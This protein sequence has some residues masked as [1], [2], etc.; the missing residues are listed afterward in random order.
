MFSANNDQNSTYR[1][2]K[3]FIKNISFIVLCCVWLSL[4]ACGGK[5]DEQA[6]SSEEEPKTK[7]ESLVEKATSN[8]IAAEIQSNKEKWLSHD[9]TEYQIEMQ[10][11]CFCVPDAVRLM[12]FE[13]ANNEIHAVRYADTGDEVDPSH[14]NQYNTVEGLFLLVEEALAKN[15][16]DISIAYDKEYGYIK[17]LSIDYQVNI[18]DDETTIIASNMKPYK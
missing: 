7:I 2:L 17:E 18:A 15:P 6:A 1:F 16:A 10:K 5:E 12:I 13:I 4:T 9:I 11:I 3:G 8:D 14:Y